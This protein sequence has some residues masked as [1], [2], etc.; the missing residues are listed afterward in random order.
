[1]TFGS[2]DF[3]DR[4]LLIKGAIDALTRLKYSGKVDNRL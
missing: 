3:L 2:V 1:M 4:E